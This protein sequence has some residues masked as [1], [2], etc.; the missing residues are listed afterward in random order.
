MKE[1]EGGFEARGVVD[2]RLFDYLLEL[3]IKRANRYLYFF[4]LLAVQPDLLPANNGMK[5]KPL[6]TRL[7]TLIQS[8][9]RTSDVVGRIGTDT[10]FLLIHQADEGGSVIVGERVRGRVEN[11][12]FT[13]DREHEGSEKKLTISLGGVCFPTHATTH[14][15]LVHTLKNML[16]KARSTGGNRTCLPDA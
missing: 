7:G 14:N 2:E 13:A 8:E 11:Y 9:I 16:A 1:I 10:Y 6:L 3:E 5:D 15:D 12:T 4:S